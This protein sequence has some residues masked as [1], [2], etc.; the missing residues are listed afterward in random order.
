[1]SATSEHLESN[2]SP[3]SIEQALMD[4]PRTRAIPG[5]PMLI[6][7]FQSVCS[8][9]E[10]V[11]DEFITSQGMFPQPSS[12]TSVLAGFVAIAREFQI[13]SEC[14]FHHRYILN[15]GSKTISTEWTVEAE[16]RLH[17]I[18]RDLPQAIQDPM[19]NLTEAAKQSFA[20]QRAN[21]LITAA[22]AKFALVGRRNRLEVPNESSLTI[23]RSMISAQ[24][25]TWMKNRSAE[26]EKQ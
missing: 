15:T 1:M 13:I 6:N 24:R 10:P 11:D 4:D 14:F 21:I 25:W 19:T 12:R 26:N 9:P 20:M 8:L 3:L 2:I 18:L 22:I 16:D 7:D 5:P 17:R 23:P